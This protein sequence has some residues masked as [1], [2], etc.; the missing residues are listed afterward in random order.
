MIKGFKDKIADNLKNI[1]HPPQ[2]MLNS[3]Y[4]ERSPHGRI[5]HPKGRVLTFT[6]GG[7]GAYQRSACDTPKCSVAA[8]GR[9]RTE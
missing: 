3:N 1:D 6:T 5:L 9:Q 7:A 4:S 2:S 8:D